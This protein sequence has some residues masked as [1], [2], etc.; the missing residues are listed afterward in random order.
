MADPKAP[1]PALDPG[2]TA[3]W[4]GGENGH[5]L[6]CRCRSCRRW[7]HPPVPVCRFCLSTDIM[8]DPS[9]GRG[10][11]LTYTVNRQ[12]WL[13][14]L[15]PPYVIAVIE[16]DDDPDLRL[17]SRLVGIEPEE[18]FIGMRVGVRF[19]RAGDVW[20]PVFGIEQAGQ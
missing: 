20:L 17:T 2:N 10:K 14:T 19:E 12:P 8:T 5:L 4:T 16:L 3:F 13:P 18:V 9:C 11:V 7:L 15:P 1:L 6:I